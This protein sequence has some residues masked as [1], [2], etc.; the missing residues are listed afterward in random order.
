[1]PGVMFALDSHQKQLV[2]VILGQKKT[3]PGFFG[4]FQDAT[5]LLDVQSVS[6]FHKG[7]GLT[8]FGKPDLVMKNAKGDLA[9]VD[10]KTAKKQPAEH[11][12]TAKYI[13][14]TNFYGYL[15]EQSDAALKVSKVG[16]LNYEFGPLSD[17]EI[18]KNIEEEQCWV[19]F[20]PVMT[21]VTY[22]PETIVVPVL[23]HV[24]DLIDQEGTPSGNEGCRDCKL[25]ESFRDLIESR[26][27]ISH[28]YLTDRERLREFYAE[29]AR[30]LTV[31]DPARQ[32]LLDSVLSA[33]EPGGVLEAWT[34]DGLF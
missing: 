20:N 4:P 30:R 11:P 24:R 9:V 23:E 3:L 27:F 26:D 25:L 32:S 5:E 1:M 2:R 28:P 15:L 17:N 8:L 6:G 12:L 16:I 14:Q 7:T 13:V 33:G 10:N 34:E 19:R 18:L 21:E 29:R 22:D 31:I